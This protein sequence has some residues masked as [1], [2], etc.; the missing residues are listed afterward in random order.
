MLKLLNAMG[1]LTRRQARLESNRLLVM[2]AMLAACTLEHSD[3][4]KRAPYYAKKV[5]E[6]VG[7]LAPNLEK[8]VFHQPEE[9]HDER[10][11][12][13]SAVRD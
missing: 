12:V 2:A 3:L 11:A 4:S 8:L 13:V 1:L 7:L 6:A 9:V 5:R 10:G